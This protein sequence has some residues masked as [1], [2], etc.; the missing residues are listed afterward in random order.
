[1]TPKELQQIESFIRLLQQRPRGRVIA[2][3]MLDSEALI[4]PVMLRDFLL[5]CAETIASR[6]DPTTTPETVVDDVASA[7]RARKSHYL[8]RC[9]QSAFVPGEFLSTTTNHRT[10][11]ARVLHA[12][13]K[14]PAILPSALPPT[15]MDTRSGIAEYRTRLASITSTPD[16][17][18]PDATL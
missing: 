11:F 10:F 13:A 3:N 18:E 2:V 9:Q 8:R 6:S 15:V 16:W 17:F 4:P 1:M 7:D 5:E 14:D 12:R